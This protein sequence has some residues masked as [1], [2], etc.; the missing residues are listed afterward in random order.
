MRE[1]V[2][3]FNLNDNIRLRGF[4]EYEELIASMANSDI[5]CFPCLYEAC[6]VGMIEAMS[7]GKPIL[8]FRTAFSRELLGDDCKLPLATCIHDYARCLHLLCTSEGLR[9]DC[10]AYL[11]ARARDR[12]D[13]RAIAGRYRDLYKRVLS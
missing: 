12:F 7:L 11:Q 6:P 10:Q 1:L 8:A 13:I 9:N 3:R 2:S 4:V 5:V